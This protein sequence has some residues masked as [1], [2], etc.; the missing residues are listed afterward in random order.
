MTRK[1]LRKII[2]QLLLMFCILKIKKNSYLYL[3]TQFRAWK[4]YPLKG[5]R[6]WKIA[7]SCHKKTICI[8]KRNNIYLE[9]F[10]GV[11]IPHKENKLLEFTQYEKS[12]TTPILI[13]ADTEEK[14][15]LDRF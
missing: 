1:K 7:L 9:Q 10:C 8:I 14:G 3:K 15:I 2:K 11:G 4:K 5:F 12:T 13:N 6:Q